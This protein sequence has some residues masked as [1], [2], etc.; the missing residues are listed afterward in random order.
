M[1]KV[2][3]IKLQVNTYDVVPNFDSYFDE[4]YQRLNESI[5]KHNQLGFKVVTVTPITSGTYDLDGCGYSYTKG[6]MIVYEKID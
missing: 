2:E 5:N 3:Y 4:A 1:N 6:L